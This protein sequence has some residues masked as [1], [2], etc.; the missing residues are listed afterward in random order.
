VA[1][2]AASVGPVHPTTT[3][4]DT[5]DTVTTFLTRL[6]E[7]DPDQVAVVFA[8]EVDWEL[9]WPAA[10]HPAVPWIRPRSTRADVADHFRELADF[11]VPEEAAAEVTRILVDGADAVV[12]GRL[13]QTVRTT[14]RSYTSPF[15]LH[16]TVEGGL[17]SRY[18]IFEDSLG[19]ATA[20]A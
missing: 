1:G 18:H 14:G 7:G 2:A 9:A 12:L 4:A 15:A 19:I 8:D 3:D 5:R 10:G 16:L 17:I 20:L 13:R 11:H 6:A